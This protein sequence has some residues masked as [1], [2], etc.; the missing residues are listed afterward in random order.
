MMCSLPGRYTFIG[1]RGRTLIGIM[2][3]NQLFKH[4][5]SVAVEIREETDSQI[6]VGSA[7]G[8]TGAVTMG[9]VIWAMRGSTSLAS[10]L[11]TLPMWQQLDPSFVLAHWEKGRRSQRRR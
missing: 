10:M 7:V 8:L 6:V 11:A 2:I 1:L 5:D 4:L 3:C 9:Y